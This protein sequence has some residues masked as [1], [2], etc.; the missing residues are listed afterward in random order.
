MPAPTMRI[1]DEVVNSEGMLT[2]D[3]SLS[4]LEDNRLR[5][6]GT[7]KSGVIYWQFGEQRRLS[8]RVKCLILIGFPHGPSFL[9]YL[10]S[11][12]SFR[13]GELHELAFSRS[14]RSTVYS[15]SATGKCAAPHVL[16]NDVGLRPDI[17]I[18][19]I[20][21]H[22]DGRARIGN[23]HYPG[24]MPLHRR[25]AEQQVDLVV[26]VSVATQILDDPQTG[27]SVGNGGVE[28]MLLSALIDREAF[29]G[30]VAAG[31]EGGLDRARVEHGGLH[32]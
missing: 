9:L 27:L 14:E 7:S 18:E 5:L 24:Q 8:T 15:G 13:R 11:A 20:H 22:A 17:E 3:L 25:T 29:K 19:N 28:V 30:E 26:T 32:V 16:P 4:C 12:I 2:F 21:R 6:R 23:I 1:E 31:P 10:I